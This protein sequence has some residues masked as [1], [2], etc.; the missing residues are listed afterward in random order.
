MKM[1][2]NSADDEEQLATPEKDINLPGHDSAESVSPEPGDYGALL[3]MTRP[4]VIS[5]DAAL[6]LEAGD[7]RVEFA[8]RKG[9]IIC[10]DS[11]GQSM[12][13]DGGLAMTRE[14]ARTNPT[15]EGGYDVPDESIFALPQ[16]RLN[17]K[18]RIHLGMS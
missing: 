15:P 7:C 5:R 1:M 14:G 11:S 6:S 9:E 4:L 2:D 8:L 12:R 10:P 17:L 13:E 18:I 16:R 3:A